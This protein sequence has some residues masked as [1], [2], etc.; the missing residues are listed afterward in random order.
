LARV[1]RHRLIFG[2]LL[3]LL[4]ASLLGN[5]LLYR[6]ATRLLFDEDDQPLIDRTA[7]HFARSARTSATNIK[8]E[9]FPIV[10]RFGDR[11]CIELRRHDRLGR[12]GACYDR[13]GRLIE[14]TAGVVN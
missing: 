4:A 10:M 13:G 14:E 12:Q 9:S 2:T 5:V 7:A 3:L 8:A 11:T 1:T 6:Q